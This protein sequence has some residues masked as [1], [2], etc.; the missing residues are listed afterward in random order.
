MDKE[1]L[2]TM[3]TKT[4]YGLM[5]LKLRFEWEGEGCSTLMII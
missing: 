1:D 3:T 4:G 2:F 5:E